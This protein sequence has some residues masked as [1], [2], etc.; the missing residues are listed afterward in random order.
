MRRG[1]MAALIVVG[2]TSCGGCGGS[3]PPPPAR[4]APSGPWYCAFVR[5]GDGGIVTPPPRCSPA[6]CAGCC[7][8]NGLCQ[9]GNTDLSC[10]QTGQVC[11][12]CSSFG[13]QCI[14]NA[15]VVVDA[16]R[17]SA[18]N[19]SGCCT[20]EGFCSNGISNAAC[21]PR[22]F[23]CATCDPGFGCER[24]QC[25]RQCNGASCPGCC[26]T[27]GV[28]V[29]GFSD[30]ACGRGG[31][32]CQLCSAPTTCS[33]SGAC[34]GPPSCST[35]Q[36]GECCFNGAC[37]AVGAS[38][39][40]RSG[41]PNADCRLCLPPASCGGGTERG[42]CVTAGTRPLGAPCLWDG[43]CAAGAASG[44]PLC[45]TGLAWPSGYCSDGCTSSPCA[46]PDVCSSFQSQ[47]VCL[48]GCSTPGASCGDA[49]TIC[50]LVGDAGP[51]CL[52]KCTPATAA[53]QCASA[54]CHV[55]GRCCGASG[56]VCCD[57]GAPCSGSASDGG[58]SSCLPTGRCS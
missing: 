49:G 28:C 8:T 37:V 30:S 14:F 58:R 11:T 54:R 7:D 6:T 12:S 44:R 42:F 25:V 38:A 57:T 55:D 10:G 40:A 33:S 1:A 3:T 22:G 47:D 18:A 13:A 52:P 43:E 27:N 16:P 36:E 31:V 26:D 20:V 17:C 21:G 34:V 39:C 15:C 35:C 23:T 2:F 29:Q 9:R 56:N 48:K 51:A 46:A 32:A 5:C 53:V 50:E 45:L 4:P 19:C 24:Q 41:G